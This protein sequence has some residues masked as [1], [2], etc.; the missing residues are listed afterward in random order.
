MYFR[1]FIKRK[2]ENQLKTHLVHLLVSGQKRIYRWP[3]CR[4][5]KSE[6]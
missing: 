2:T 3:I 6:R 1:F 4:G 5:F